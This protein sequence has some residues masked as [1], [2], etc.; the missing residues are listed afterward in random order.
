MFPYTP[1]FIISK[2][3]NN[4][5][6]QA[7]NIVLK[8]DENVIKKKVED[9]NIINKSKQK[10]FYKTKIAKATISEKGG[11]G[12]GLLKIAKTSNNKFKYAFNTINKKYTYYTIE[13]TIINKKLEGMSKYQLEQTEKTP[14][15]IFDPNNWLFEMEGNSRPENVRGFYKPIIEHFEEFINVEAPKLS[16]DQKNTPFVIR[17]KLDYFNSS[18][19]KFILDLIMLISRFQTTG[20]KP[21]IEWYFEEGDDDMKEAGEEFEELIEQEFKYIMIKED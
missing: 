4:Y 7:G 17:F 12:L 18:S 9:I 11:A 16:D 6:I 10:E 15:I 20:V 1:K 2:V 14:R 21:Q 13:I 3:N 8:S 19:A 5:Q